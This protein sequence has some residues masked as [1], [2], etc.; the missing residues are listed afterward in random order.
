MHNTWIFDILNQCM[1]YMHVS[2]YSLLFYIKRNIKRTLCRDPAKT[3]S[4]CEVVSVA[5]G[6]C[7]WCALR[8]CFWSAMASVI[9]GNA[10]SVGLDIPVPQG[11]ITER[12]IQLGL[13]KWTP[14]ERGQCAVL[15]LEVLRDK[16]CPSKDLISSNLYAFT[17]TVRVSS[18]TAVVLPSSSC[19]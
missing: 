7:L 9:G 2:M 11:S 1:Y 8:F 19:F 16:H 13:F 18:L 17:Q 3:A 6:F 10:D 15:K 4:V 12:L 14:E 5:Q